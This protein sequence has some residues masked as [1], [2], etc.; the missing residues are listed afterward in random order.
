AEAMLVDARKVVRL[1]ADIDYE[2]AAF[3]Y[4]PTLGLHA[5]RSAGYTVGENVVV[6]GQ[7]IVGVLAAGLASVVGAR[8]A[9]FE[10]DPTRR[11][12]AQGAGV[13]RILDPRAADSNAQLEAFFGEAGPDVIVETSQS[14]SG[15]AHA[16][17][18]AHAG[19]RIAVVGIYR[20]E[21]PPEVAAALLRA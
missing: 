13:E 21:P 1:P 10:P 9:A 2:A 5:L 14:W 18:L 4:L 17:R 11:L 20:T 3:T 12:V 8:V 19:T 7:G 15:L 6:I 16:M